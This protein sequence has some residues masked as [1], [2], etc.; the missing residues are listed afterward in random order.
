MLRRRG[1]LLWVLLLPPVVASG[2]NQIFGIVGG[3]NTA[4]STGTPTGS[5]SSGGAGA[6]ST[7]G[8]TSTAAGT[9]GYHGGAASSRRR[10]TG[11]TGATA[12]TGGGVAGMVTVTPAA[13]TL[14]ALT[15]LTFTAA[16]AGAAAPSSG[17]TDESGGGTVTATGAYAAPLTDG[18][19]HLRATSVAHPTE[20]GEATITVHQ[21]VTPATL[22]ATGELPDATGNGSQSH[23]IYASG[24]GEWW[25]FHDPSGGSQL[26]TEHSTDFANWA[27][28]A[29]ISLPQNNSGFGR[30]LSVAYRR[31]GTGDVV[32][33]TPGV[34]HR[35]TAAPTSGA[36]T[37]AP[38]SRPARSTRATRT[39]STT[40][41]APRPTARPPR[42]S[43]AAPWSSSTT[44]PLGRMAVAEPSGEAPPPVLMSYTL[45]AW[46][47]PAVEVARMW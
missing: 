11:G 27:P 24:T 30:D 17:A 25:L 1:T 45:P 2:C 41:E 28:G 46:M 9:G 22:V 37:S 43:R 14:L 31:I 29:L 5:S 3:E 23:L 20:Y 10:G 4:S 33:I 32:H 12:G 13:T 21:T 35:E 39:T 36:T 16:G 38:R 40:E 18:T 42:S 7:T 47:W 26:A 8:T 15:T 19:Y 44:V 6:G 34:C